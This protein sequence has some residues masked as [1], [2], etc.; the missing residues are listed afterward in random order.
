MAGLGGGEP[1]LGTMNIL[2][3]I[4]AR[5]GSRRVPNK[6]IRSLGGHPLIAW[7]ISAARQ[8][9][10]LSEWPIVVSSDS[11]KILDI[12]QEWGAE[13]LKRPASLAAHDAEAYPALMHAIDVQP[14]SYDVVC[15]LQPTSPFRAPYDIDCCI[16]G[17]MYPD[18]YPAV[19]SV[20]ADGQVPNG[21]VYVGRI[22]WLREKLSMGVL[23]PFDE[24]HCTRYCMPSCRSLDID[25]EGD[26]ALA[27][28]M[29]ERNVA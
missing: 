16:T 12:A 18:S 28:S 4:L 29:F 15:L 14:I 2:T 19:V 23:R 25:T 1:E 20:T 24:P 22:D 8:S 10:Y 3:V 6:N 27:E 17:L 9:A 26:F 13:P 11:D 21:A 7:T 5:G